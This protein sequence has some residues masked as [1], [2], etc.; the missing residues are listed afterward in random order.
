MFGFYCAVFLILPHG[1]R[2][3]PASTGNPNSP[4]KRL[5]QGIFD[6]RMPEDL[7]DQFSRDK[8]II[9]LVK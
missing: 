4:K 7:D 5:K 3:P 6:R 2:G 9:R 8:L 1:R